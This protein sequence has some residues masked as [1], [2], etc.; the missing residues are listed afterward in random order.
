[1]TSIAAS[2][3]V[4]SGLDTSALVT[5]LSAA[6]RDPKEAVI[7][8]RES[9]NTAKIS[10]LGNAVSGIDAFSSSLTGLVAGGNLFTQPNSSDESIVSASAIAGSR[11]GSL[12]ATLEIKQLATAQTLVSG[13]IAG[14]TSAIGQGTLNLTT[15]NGSFAVTIDGSND[16]LE[17]LAK[18]INDAG[19]GLAASIVQD[20]A[21]A[22]LVVKSATGAA[23]AF[24][25]T[26]TA[27]TAG[28]GRFAYDAGASTNPMTAAQ[29]ARDALIVYD[30][31]TVTRATNSVSDLVPGVKL[32]LKSAAIGTTVSLG[33]TRPTTAITNA[34]TDFVD[35]YNSLKSILDEATAPRA[36]DGTGGGA[37]RGDVGIR[38][39]QRQLA[40]LTSTV[41]GGSGSGPKTLAEIGVSTN[42]DGTLA[43]DTNKLSAILASDPDG[44]EALFN[45]SQSSSSSLLKITSLSGK[46]APG[47]Y[48]ISNVTTAPLGG[49]IAGFPALVSGNSLIASASSP[50]AG[51]VLAVTGDVASATITVDAGIGGALK[52]IRDAL[53]GADGPLASAQAAAK[54]ETTTIA[55][56]RAKMEER[57]TTYTTRLTTAFSTMDTR[58]AAYKATQSYMEQQI[59]LWTNDS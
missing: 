15:A 39:M 8:K 3:G 57:V 19:A 33:A 6:V 54:K 9:V 37:L 42:R 48:A 41:L 36:A 1:M 47:S 50:A 56:D 28:L 20:S 58:V 51:L 52:A 25:M 38:E 4:G 29:S 21:G 46:T 23:K 44:V 5:Q 10:A 2:L 49:T 13:N 40:K 22:R 7:A 14:T 35:A 11:L 12:S 18:A 53:R 45:P 16:S 24:T 17:G 26:T 32:E 34:V 30:G 55:D 43:L 27:D 31:V 59:K